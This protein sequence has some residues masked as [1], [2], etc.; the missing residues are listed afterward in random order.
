VTIKM[1]LLGRR[2]FVDAAKQCLSKAQYLK[3]SIAALPGYELPFSAPTYN[4]FTVRVRG[5]DAGNLVSALVHQGLL[6][7]YDLGRADPVLRDLLLIAVT[8]RHTRED[9]DRLA[10]ALDT[11]SIA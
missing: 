4:E 2:G 1:S 9:I 10:Q 11:Y 6:A 3:Q 8:E 5:G 7:G